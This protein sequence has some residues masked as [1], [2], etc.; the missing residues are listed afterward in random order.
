MRCHDDELRQAIH[1]IGYGDAPPLSGVPYS[2]NPR[3]DISMDRKLFQAKEASQD[4]I[5]EMRR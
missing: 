5:E 3:A 2:K 1:D 4:N